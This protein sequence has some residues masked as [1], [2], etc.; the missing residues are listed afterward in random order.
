[1]EKESNENELPK[2]LIEDVQKKITEIRR[3]EDPY[4]GDQGLYIDWP[5]IKENVDHIKMKCILLNQ[6]INEKDT[7]DTR[8]DCLRM[9]YDI[10]DHWMEI[11][12]MMDGKM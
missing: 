4:Y 2:S 8:K 5:R 11:R 10:R 12:S 7:L 3:S 9:A 1:M 6:K